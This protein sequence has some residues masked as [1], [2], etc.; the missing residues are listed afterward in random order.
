MAELGASGPR[1]DRPQQQ[2]RLGQDGG[3]GGKEPDPPRLGA[4]SSWGGW[5]TAA[6]GSPS[7]Q[8]SCAHTQVWGDRTLSNEW[9]V[10]PA[11]PGPVGRSRIADSAPGSCQTR[12]TVRAVLSTDVTQL[13]RARVP[14]TYVTTGTD[15]PPS[16]AAFQRLR[17]KNTL[18]VTRVGCISTTCS[19]SK[20]L[21]PP[22]DRLRPVT[23]EPHRLPARQRAELMK[24]CYLPMDAMFP[25]V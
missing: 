13:L 9:R 6:R 24:S 17:L 20:P 18:D 7:R 16:P 14:H 25:K 2:S 3:H 23:H 11:A 1:G 5:P 10:S 21:K 22:G 4:G 12:A 8:P 19:L 15:A